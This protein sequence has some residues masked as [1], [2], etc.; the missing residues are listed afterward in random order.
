MEESVKER[1]VKFTTI[2]K[3]IL[4]KEWFFF[5]YL[6]RHRQFKKRMYEENKTAYNQS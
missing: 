3:P 1:L 5:V 2:S 6:Q 4:L